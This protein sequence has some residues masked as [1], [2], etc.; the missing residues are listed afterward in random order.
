MLRPGL[1]LHRP[2]PTLSPRRHDE[3]LVVLDRVPALPELGHKLARRA[4]RGARSGM[5]LG[6]LE[7]RAGPACEAPTHLIEWLRGGRESAP[8]SNWMVRHTAA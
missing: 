3:L 8:H 5:R 7:H 6:H 2:R 1:G 4:P